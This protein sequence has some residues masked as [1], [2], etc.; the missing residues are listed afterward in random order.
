MALNMAD[1]IAVLQNVRTRV[2]GAIASYAGVKIN[3]AEATEGEKAW[4]L[5]AL[6]SRS[7]FV[8][9]V[10]GH[11]VHNSAYITNGSGISESDLDWIVQTTLN[12]HVIPRFAPGSGGE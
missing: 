9:E 3:D 12:N 7:Q 5:Q 11:C 4:A 8:D 2:E 6:R 1:R 10:S